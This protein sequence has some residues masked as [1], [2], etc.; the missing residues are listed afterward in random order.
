MDK[1]KEPMTIRDLIRRADIPR[2][3]IPVFE[4]LRLE[5]FQM[6]QSVYDDRVEAYDVDHPP[7]E[8]QVYGPISLASEC[9]KRARRLASLLSPTRELPLRPADINRSMDICIDTINYLSWTYALI[10][11]ASGFE[12]H[13][14][15][16]DAPNYLGT[17]DPGQ[18]I[19]NQFKKGSNRG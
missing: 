12:G 16:D 3:L 13:A 19:P 15:S 11:L 9:F 4:K 17:V 5:A 6:A 8:E 7:Y 14:N 1:T 18:P 2:E 10:K